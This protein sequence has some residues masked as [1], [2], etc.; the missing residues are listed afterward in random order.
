MDGHILKRSK[1]EKDI[2]VHIDNEL[3][4]HEHINKAVNKA[5]RVMAVTR[6]TFSCLNNSTFLPI[7]KGL[8]RPQLEYAAP[9][10]SPHHLELKRKIERVQRSA[11]KRLPGMHDLHYDQRLRKLKL[12]TLAYR[13]IRGDMIQVFKLIMPIKKGAYDRSLPK[14]LDLKAD[15]GIREV[16]GHDKQIY[17]TGNANKDIKKYGFNFRVS[18]LW[19]SLPQ[20]VINAKTVKSFEIALDKHWADQPVLYDNFEAEIEIN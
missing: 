12:P 9:V 15:L 11:T 1:C 13:R 3:N 6:K 4:F 18:K 17:C 2:G 8:V 20:E 5:N 16:T 14:L 10:W 19:N 7:F